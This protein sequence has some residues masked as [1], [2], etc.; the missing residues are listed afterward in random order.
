VAL[1]W[2]ETLGWVEHPDRVGVRAL[3][4]IAVDP[5]HAVEPDLEAIASDL[6]AVET[7]LA[8]LED[9][10]YPDDQERPEPDPA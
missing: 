1:R 2:A 10:T 3:A 4:S 5:D 8:Q 9:G 6:A 7:A